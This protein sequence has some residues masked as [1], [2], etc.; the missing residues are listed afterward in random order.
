[1]TFGIPQIPHLRKYVTKALSENAP[2]SVIITSARLLDPAYV[3]RKSRRSRVHKNASTLVKTAAYYVPRSHPPDP[4]H[5]RTVTNWLPQALGPARTSLRSRRQTFSRKPMTSRAHSPEI[6]H[7]IHTMR[8]AA[9]T[10]VNQQ[11]DMLIIMLEI[12]R[13]SDWRPRVI[14]AFNVA[15]SRQAFPEPLG[16][17]AQDSVRQ[18]ACLGI[19][20]Y[21]QVL[22]F[23]TGRICRVQNCINLRAGR[24]RASAGTCS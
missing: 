19:L 8:C 11:L 22:R 9:E 5:T 10:S 13:T 12:A 23:I 21:S 20:L 24:P 16:V 6:P 17:G 15:C 18:I 7:I 1:M 3:G 14:H 4:A 2:R